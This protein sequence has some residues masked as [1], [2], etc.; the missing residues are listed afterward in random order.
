MENFRVRLPKLSKFVFRQETSCFGQHEQQAAANR[1]RVGQEEPDGQVQD[2]LFVQEVRFDFEE[3]VTSKLTR[4]ASSVLSEPTCTRAS[5]NCVTFRFTFA[6]FCTNG[7]RIGDWTSTFC[8]STRPSKLSKLCFRMRRLDLENNRKKANFRGRGTKIEIIT[9]KG[10][11][12]KHNNPILLPNIY[13][14][15]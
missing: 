4:W 11:H 12:S 2:L 6:S 8:T 7:P 5:K 1:V 14:W 3:N 15:E 13:K 9:G 10:K